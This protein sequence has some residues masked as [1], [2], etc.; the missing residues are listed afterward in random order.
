LR[1]LLGRSGDDT[2][3][4]FGADRAG[5]TSAN[6]VYPLYDGALL[7]LTDSTYVDREGVNLAEEPIVADHRTLG[8]VLRIFL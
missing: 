6:S 2:V 1:G 4:S 7:V 5:C 8:A 3:R